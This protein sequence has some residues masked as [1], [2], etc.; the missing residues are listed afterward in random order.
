M[1][2]SSID[3]VRLGCGRAGAAA[4]EAAGSIGIEGDAAAGHAVLAAMNF[5]V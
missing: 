3:F 5:M 2:L 4:L 1:T